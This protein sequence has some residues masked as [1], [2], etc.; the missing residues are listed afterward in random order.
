MLRSIAWIE[1]PIVVLF[2]NSVNSSNS[3]SPIYLFS[4]SISPALFWAKYPFDR[5]LITE[6]Q[7]KIT[8]QKVL[9][10]LQPSSERRFSFLYSE[11]L[12]K[13]APALIQFLFSW[14][15]LALERPIEL[16]FRISCYFCCWFCNAIKLP[17]VFMFLYYPGFQ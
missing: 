8:V 17:E 11:K 9:E 5:F 2:Y 10:K 7:S 13:K 16:A 1:I 3:K 14:I 4:C 12:I 6:K 15:S